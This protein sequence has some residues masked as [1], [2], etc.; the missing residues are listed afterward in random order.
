MSVH[1]EPA[2]PAMRMLTASTLMGITHA[3][4]IMVTKA[5]GSYVKV[6]PLQRCNN[7]YTHTSL[8]SDIN[9]CA[10]RTSNECHENA[11]CINTDA[12]YTCRS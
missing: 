11:D 1:I 5:M 10:N 2:M 9:E 7:Y 12:N 6:R 8:H 3:A 4:V